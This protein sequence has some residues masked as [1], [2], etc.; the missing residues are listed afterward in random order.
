MLTQVLQAKNQSS[1][2]TR[3]KTLNDVV[4]FFIAKDM[5]TVNDSGFQHILTKGNTLQTGTLQKLI[6]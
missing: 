2:S 5:Q 6:P 1:N 3:W 4:H